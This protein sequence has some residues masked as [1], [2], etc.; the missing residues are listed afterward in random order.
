MDQ[1]QLALIL[2][3]AFFHPLGDQQPIEAR[4]CELINSPDL[5]HRQL[6]YVREPTVVPYGGLVNPLL[7][8]IWN[9]AGVGQQTIPTE[10]EQA[11]IAARVLRVGLCGPE[12]PATLQGSAQLLQPPPVCSGYSPACVLRPE[13][14]ARVIV[15]PRSPG[16]AVPIRVLVIPSGQLTTDNGPLTTDHGQLTTDN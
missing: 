5:C 6:L 4:T 13:P 1:S 10:E 8:L 7:I 3:G 11:A 15:A 2:S 14:G 9:L 16:E 12:D